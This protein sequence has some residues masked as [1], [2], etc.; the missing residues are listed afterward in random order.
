MDVALTHGVGGL[1]LVTKRQGSRGAKEKL[2]SLKKLGLR[3]LNGTLLCQLVHL[4]DNH[5]SL[6]GDRILREDPAEID[7]GGEI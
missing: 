1:F 7:T 6:D 5:H 3:L 4:S 2:N